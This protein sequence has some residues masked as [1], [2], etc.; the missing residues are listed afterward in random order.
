MMRRLAVSTALGLL[1]AHVAQADGWRLVDC[2]TPNTG[3]W[4]E[5]ES[6]VRSAQPG[7]QLY[8]LHPFPKSDQEVYEAFTQ[9]FLAMFGSQVEQEPLVRP[10]PHQKVGS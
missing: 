8:T 9:Q 6:S 7:S 10:H 1:V 2:T 4:Q 3:A 5:Y